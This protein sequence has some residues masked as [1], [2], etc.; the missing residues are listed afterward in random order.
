MFSEHD[1]LVVLIILAL[2]CFH[3]CSI[4]AIELDEDLSNVFVFHEIEDDLSRHF[5]A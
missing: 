3:L 4:F 2:P 1:K 5:I